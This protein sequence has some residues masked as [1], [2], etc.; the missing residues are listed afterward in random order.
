M[1]FTTYFQELEIL[2]KQKNKKI[3]SFHMFEKSLYIVKGLNLFYILKRATYLQDVSEQLC[4]VCVAAVE[5]LLTQLFR[6][7]HSCIDLAST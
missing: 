2:T 1:I 4:P 7:L 3:R 6:F 5:E